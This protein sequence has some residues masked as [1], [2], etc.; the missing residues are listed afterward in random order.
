MTRVRSAMASVRVE[1]VAAVRTSLASM[2]E[3]AFSKGTE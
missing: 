3:R 2:A 1:V